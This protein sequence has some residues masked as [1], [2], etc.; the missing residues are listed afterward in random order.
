MFQDAGSSLPEATAILLAVDLFLTA[1]GWWLLLL[2]A[3]LVTLFIYAMREPRSRLVIDRFFLN[4]RLTFDL[5]ARYEAA[6]FCRSFQTLL[7]GGLSLESALALARGGSSNSWFIRKLADGPVQRRRRRAS[8]HCR[9]KSAVLPAARGGIRR[10]R[11][12]D[13]PRG[14]R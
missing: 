5:P 13:R 2:T 9:S 11:R 8:S 12:G 7:D 3:C 14:E 10:G 1:Y 6:R 4:G